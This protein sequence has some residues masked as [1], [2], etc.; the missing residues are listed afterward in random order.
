MLPYE[1]VRSSAATDGTL[2]ALA[3]S[4]HAAAADLA[5]WDSALRDD[6]NRLGA[7]WRTR[8]PATSDSEVDV[9][10]D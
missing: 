10:V 1:A 5:G 9:L 2:L 8:R 7:W 3:E 4:T 6:T